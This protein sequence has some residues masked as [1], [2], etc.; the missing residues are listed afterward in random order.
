MKSLKVYGLAL[1]LSG[2]APKSSIIYM[3]RE[4]DR[5]DRLTYSVSDV[6]DRVKREI[7]EAQENKG[8]ISPMILETIMRETSQRGIV[9]QVEESEEGT[10]VSAYP[11]ILYAK[12]EGVEAYFKTK[13]TLH[14]KDQDGILDIP[15]ETREM[16]KNSANICE[17]VLKDYKRRRK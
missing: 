4:I 2:C 13:I 8:Q 15:P 17:K 10:E 12:R 11:P 7:L 6:D 14:D 5:P 1:L 16:L 3:S 9:V